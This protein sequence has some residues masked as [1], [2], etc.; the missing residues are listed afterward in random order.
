MKYWNEPLSISR[1]CTPV[2]PG[3][4]HCWFRGL[5]H[6]FPDQMGDPGVVR[7]DPK[8][9]AK[10]ERAKKPRVWSAWADLFHEAID[11]DTI[12]RCLEYFERAKDQIVLVLTKRPERAMRLWTHPINNVW[13]GTSA[14]DQKTFDERWPY[15]VAVKALKPGM[16]Y[17][18][19]S[20][21]GSAWRQRV[22]LS[23]EPL[24]GPIV[25]NKACLPDVV[26]AG[27]ETGAGARPMQ[28]EWIEYLSCNCISG[29][30]PFIRK[31]KEWTDF[32]ALEFWR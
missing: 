1:G 6:R 8:P 25:L 19:V 20:K 32:N 4:D 3:C 21:E 7:F 22:F 31:D 11:D 12:L 15:M 30:I 28:E 18:P 29:N 26:I 13:L 23:A 27:P 17:D 24:L 14:E 5:Q 9:L 2:S 10:F 16:I